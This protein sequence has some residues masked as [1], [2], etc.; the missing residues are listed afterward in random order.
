MKTLSGLGAGGAV[1]VIWKSIPTWAKIV[2]ISGIAVVTVAEIVIDLNHAGNAPQMFQGQ[3]DAITADARQK[4]AVADAANTSVE[5]IKA[6][7]IRGENVT[8][9]ESIQLKEY[10]IKENQARIEKAKAIN[11]EIGAIYNSAVYQFLGG[12]IKATQEK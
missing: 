1:L 10:E 3:A 5:N 6:R 4:K 8:V 9:T 12:L 7:L 11:E 2:L